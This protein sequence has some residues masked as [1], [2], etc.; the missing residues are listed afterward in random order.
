[1]LDEG[2]G[3][4]SAVAPTH[5]ERQLLVRLLAYAPVLASLAT[6]DATLL[7]LCSPSVP[8]HGFSPHCSSLRLSQQSLWVLSRR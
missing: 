7:L 1:M 3:V 4:A 5:L 8:I 6:A 2:W